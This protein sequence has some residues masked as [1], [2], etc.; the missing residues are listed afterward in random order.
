M[1]TIDAASVIEKLNAAGQHQ[2]AA[3]V[4]IEALRN[5]ETRSRVR[6]FTSG[7]GSTPA[8][9]PQKDPRDQTALE[10]GYLSWSE[11]ARL[12]LPSV[13]RLRQEAPEMY[14][15]SLE[16]LAETRRWTDKPTNV[17]W[18]TGDAA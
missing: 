2:L 12:D 13:T 14:R 10:R 17:Q 1:T 9:G 4:A 3:E 15:A 6:E 8:A 18:S 7:N 11:L 5:D 16:H